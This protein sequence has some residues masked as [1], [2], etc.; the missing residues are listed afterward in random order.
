MAKA[1]KIKD[2]GELARVAGNIFSGITTVF[3]FMILTIFP[4]Y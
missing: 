3:T 2:S 1:A 4:L